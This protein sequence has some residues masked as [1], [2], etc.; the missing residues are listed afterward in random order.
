MSIYQKIT[1]IGS[2]FIARNTLFKYGF[3]LSPMY[4][5]STGRITKVSPDLLSIRVKLKISYKNRNYM[6]SMFGGS[7]FSAVDPIPMIQL[8]NIIGN[9]YVVWDKSAEIFFKRPV[10]QNVYADFTY[11]IQEIEDIKKRVSTENEI[12]IVKNT[13]ITSQDGSVVFC[14]VDKTIYIANKLFYKEKIAKRK[15]QRS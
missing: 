1:K 15:K 11:T 4:R 6:N 9:D 3:N 8:F 2:K 14:E 10:K 13:A 7:L 5:R 12:T